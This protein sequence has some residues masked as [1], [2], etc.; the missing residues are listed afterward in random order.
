MFKAIFMA[1]GLMLAG[2]AW[3]ADL[4][5]VKQAAIGEAEALAPD[6]ERLAR[7]LWQYS[8]PSMKEEKSAEL[9]AKYM[10]KQGFKVE[11]GVAGMKTAFVATWSMGGSG[12][13]VVGI[14]AEYD[15]LPGVGNEA[16]PRKQPVGGK[17]TPGHGC[18]HNLFGAG[19]VGAAVALKRAMQKNKINGTV[20]LFGCPAEEIAVGKVYMARAGA[21]GGLDGV[22]DWH[23]HPFTDVNN[24]SSRAAN[25]FQV[26]F[27]GKTA[28]S[29]GD[30]WNGRSALDA[31]QLMNMAADMMR[32]HVPPTTRIHYVISDGGSAPN[33]VPDY[34]RVWYFVREVDRESVE[35]TYQW[36]VDAAR[37]AALMTQTREKVT[38]ISGIYNLNLNRPF[39]EAEEKNLQLVGAPKYTQEEQAFAKA[40]QRELDVKEAGFDDTVHALKPAPEPVSGTSTDVGDV[41][42][43]APTVTLKV[44]TAPAGAPWHSWAVAAS[45]GTSGGMKG[46]VVAAKVMAATGVDMMM[47]PDLLARAKKFF[48]AS[49]AGKPYKCALP[50][51]RTEVILP[52]RTAEK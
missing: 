47:D 12:K 10:E 7:E 49:T 27:Y 40:M 28:H 48:D 3:A 8:E 39:Q 26:E 43:N 51:D 20:K 36:L 35:K 29:S 22:M 52:G 38:L 13:P 15:A 45:G 31:A 2:S 33:V 50:A 42:W 37:G 5:A 41:S 11:R 9:L 19:S 25:I 21:F 44:A 1:V 18:G 24:I 46:A 23:P 30:P 34:A 16:V 6:M 4:A 17:I 14:L 32:E